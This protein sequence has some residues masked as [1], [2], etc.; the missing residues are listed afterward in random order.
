M[1][2]NRR[3]NGSNG[4]IP[5]T[6]LFSRIERRFLR[7]GRQTALLGVMKNLA[8]ITPPSN[9]LSI[10]KPHQTFF[11]TEKAELE[12]LQRRNIFSAHLNT[13]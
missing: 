2:D 10:M 8:D 5:Q 1:T 6:T 11:F 12:R 3:N 13:M 9:L 7:S 4:F